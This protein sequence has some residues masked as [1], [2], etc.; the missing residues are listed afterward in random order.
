[1]VTYTRREYVPVTYVAVSTQRE[2]H[3][4]H[5]EDKW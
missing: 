2:T 4:R 1:M 3:G 5:L